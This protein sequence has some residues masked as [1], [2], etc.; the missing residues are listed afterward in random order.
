[1]SVS[2]LNWRP[3]TGPDT[4]ITM[5]G[6]SSV[7]IYVGYCNKMP[8]TGWLINDS[9]LFLTVLEAGRSKIKMLA[10]SVSGESL[11]SVHS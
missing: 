10:D 4:F 8:E 5:P 3:R 1:M 7:L 6:F 9:N 11:L 2:V